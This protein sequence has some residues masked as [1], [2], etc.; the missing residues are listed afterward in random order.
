MLDMII[1]KF[2]NFRVM[3]TSM[4][5]TWMNGQT[6]PLCKREDLSMAV[7]WSQGQ[8]DHLKLLWLEDIQERIVLRSTTYSLNYGGKNLIV[9]V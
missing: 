9:F 4:T 7:V 8:M 3:C 6:L 1:E 5:L 2:D